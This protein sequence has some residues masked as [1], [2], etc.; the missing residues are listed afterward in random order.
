MRINTLLLFIYLFICEFDSHCQTDPF[1]E[2]LVPNPGF[3]LVNSDGTLPQCY[4]Y[5][6]A[7]GSDPGGIGQS[8]F[9]SDVPFWD[10]ANRH[11]ASITNNGSP[12]WIAPPPLCFDYLFPGNGTWFVHCGGEKES[13]RTL[14]YKS[15]TPYTLVAG[16]RYILK[17]K[18]VN[19]SNKG[20]I[21]IIF[22]KWGEHW[23][24]NPITTG[25]QKW[26][27]SDGNLDW[28][29]PY[30]EW[31]QET[32]TFIAPSGSD[33]NSLSNLI[34]ETCKD[35]S[36]TSTQI[37]IDDVEL[38]EDDVCP[39][40]RAIEN[41][42]YSGQTKIIQAANTL[43]AGYDVGNPHTDNGNVIVKYDSKIIY[44]AGAVVSVEPGFSTEP[45]SYFEMVIEPCEANP[46]P[47]PPVLNSF[48]NSCFGNPVSIGTST[49]ETGLLYSW[50]PSIYLDNPTS[51]NPTFTPP[52][53]SGFVTY[54]V[55][56][57]SICGYLT[58]FPYFETSVIQNVTVYYNDTPD[59]IPTLTVNSFTSTDYDFN[60][61]A[62]VGP[63]TE[64]VCIEFLEGSTSITEYC[65]NTPLDFSCCDFSLN[66]QDIPIEI[67][68]LLSNCKDY[69]LRIKVKNYCYDNITSFDILWNKSNILSFDP[70]PNIITPPHAGSVG[71]GLNDYFEI[72]TTGADHYSIFVS[73][74]WGPVFS[75]SGEIISS[76]QAIWD[77]HCHSSGLT[78]CTGADLAEGS[79]AIA[80]NVWNDCSGYDGRLTQT[81]FVVISYDD[82]T[83]VIISDSSTNQMN[84]ASVGLNETIE[85]N[86]FTVFPN[87]AS[88]K[89]YI[90]FTEQNQHSTIRLF[91][92]LGEQIF[93]K[94]SNGSLMEINTENFA[95]GIYTLMVN[96]KTKHSTVKVAITH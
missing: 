70:M 85:K 36:E 78:I 8:R 88:N 40:V 24:S 45:G 81:G 27:A 14:L 74:T 47:S 39:E 21:K 76:P 73:G 94:T 1:A 77:G 35:E 15:G 30:T 46:C 49:S 56:V 80:V 64:T 42:V 92:Q 90:S 11:P 43:R 29:S 41:T 65:Q 59:P 89:F 3:E 68:E 5:Y 79:Y 96:E 83:H 13:I 2:N 48:Y 63:S 61:N 58:T 38:Y 54:T 72:T 37:V 33:Y 25:N 87:P 67:R 55:T 82:K 57:T 62:T 66:Y 69:T 10:V 44:R 23:N 50:S 75:E 19:T 28:S 51:P 86:N 6:S 91:N 32:R 34:I 9:N 60:L 93:E 26:E 31:R 20:C 4:D 12:D 16:K 95:G 18:Y 22:S 71:D 53:G 17:Y 52:S 84:R 7:I